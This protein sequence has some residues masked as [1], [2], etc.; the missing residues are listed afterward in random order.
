MT[1][2]EAK[3]QA[4]AENGEALYSILVELYIWADK[5]D[6]VGVPPSG[7]WGKAHKIKELI[8]N[9]SAE[10]E[11]YEAAIDTHS[12]LRYVSPRVQK[13]AGNY[14]WG[15][16]DGAPTLCIRDAIANIT[17]DMEETGHWADD[18]SDALLK[19]LFDLAKDGYDEVTL[20]VK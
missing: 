5:F 9:R 1:P 4:C 18:E 11:Q 20:E 6:L 3:K 8:R 7:I 15:F 16:S 10:L 13:F 19:L 17:E 14:A 2:Q 12:T